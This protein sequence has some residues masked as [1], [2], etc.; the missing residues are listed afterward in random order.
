LV[1]F[2]HF[3]VALKLLATKE[4]IVIFQELSAPMFSL[5][6]P[7]NKGSITLAA[8]S[9][10]SKVVENLVVPVSFLPIRL[11]LHQLPTPVSTAFIRSDFANSPD[12]V[13]FQGSFSHISVWMTCFFKKR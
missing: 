2:Y 13:I 11:D 1:F 4:W 5:F 8:P 12:R 6:I 3:Q 9:T 10:I 7:S